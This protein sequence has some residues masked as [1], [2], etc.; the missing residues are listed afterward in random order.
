MVYQAYVRERF[1]YDAETGVLTWRFLP[2]VNR[3]NKHFNSIWGGKRAGFI[4]KDW[5]YRCITMEGKTYKEH[6]IIWLWQYGYFPSH[7]IDHINRVSDDNRIVNLR[8]AKTDSEQAQN[9]G[10]YKNNKSG[11]PGVNWFPLYNKWVARIQLSG[12]R[13]TLGYFENFEEACQ[14]Y[15]EAK[16]KYHEFQPTIRS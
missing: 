11:Q 15:L 3:K 1:D 12:K 5:G 14:I 16:A 7:E 6:R 10:K 2:P 13:K 4:E 8:E 9:K